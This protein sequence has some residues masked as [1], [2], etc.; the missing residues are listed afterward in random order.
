MKP[1]VILEE[2]GGS[3]VNYAVEVWIDDANDIRHRNSVLHESV[4]RALKDK[5][6]LIAYPQL[7]LHLDQ[8]VVDAV[9]KQKS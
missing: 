3:S 9:A 4:W 8:N 1:E 7:D 2:F 5:G 6:K